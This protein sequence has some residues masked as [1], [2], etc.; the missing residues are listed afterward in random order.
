MEFVSFFIKKTNILLLLLP[1]NLTWISSI[2]WLKYNTISVIITSAV[3]L[4]FVH[5]LIKM[6]YF[7]FIYMAFQLD[8]V[9]FVIKIQKNNKTFGT[10]I[11]F[12]FWLRERKRSFS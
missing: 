5:Y 7:L 9:H 12:L 2:F 6:R 8:Y 3:K 10:C 11:C 4:D 1:F